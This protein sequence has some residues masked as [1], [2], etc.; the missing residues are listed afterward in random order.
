MTAS[1]PV[2]RPE[3]RFRGCTFDHRL[4]RLLA[5]MSEEA[6]VNRMSKN[7]PWR[8]S[9]EAGRAPPTKLC[10]FSFGGS[11]WI[12]NLD[13]AMHKPFLA[14]RVRSNVA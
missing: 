1:A 12:S 7:F 2:L 11:L 6:S 10:E 9:G 3:Q 4:H 5:G 8:Y 14:R 13:A